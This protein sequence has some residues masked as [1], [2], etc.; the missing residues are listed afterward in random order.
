MK[1]NL[2]N[3]YVKLAAC[4][5]AGAIIYSV[6][7]LLVDKNSREVAVLLGKTAPDFKLSS[8]QATSLSQHR[9]KPI[10]LH[11]WATWCAPCVQELPMLLVLAEKT[12]QNFT[13]IAVSE[14][15]NW[16]IVNDFLAQNPNLANLK[17][18]IFLVLDPEAHIANLYQ[19]SRFPESFLIN[20]QFIVDNKL[21]GAQNWNSTEIEKTL[22]KLLE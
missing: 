22:K 15:Q 9:G 18:S 14:D 13:Y 10:V 1:K 11:F 12:K 5:I 2:T 20:R 7:N 4:I 8:E 17:K 16:K 3:P 6:I 21:I 19:S